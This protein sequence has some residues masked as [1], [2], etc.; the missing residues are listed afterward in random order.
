M[1]QLQNQKALSGY[2]GRVM[3]QSTADQTGA[4]TTILATKWS[5]TYKTELQ[6]CSTF[7]EVTGTSGSSV[8]ANTPISRYVASMTDMD[9]SIDAFYDVNNGWMPTLRPGT[10]MKAVLYINKPASE[11]SGNK[12][13]TNVADNSTE[14]KVSINFIIENVTYDVEVRGVVKFSL[15]GKVSGGTALSFV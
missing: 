13:T 10:E 4:D 6:D 11:G 14:R 7:E 8:G 12:A 5:L 1:A 2:R 9:V 3:I 15:T